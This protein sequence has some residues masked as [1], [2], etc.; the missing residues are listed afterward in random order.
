MTKEKFFEGLE[1]ILDEWDPIGILHDFKPIRYINGVKGEYS[2]YV[3]PFWIY[4]WLINLCMIF[5]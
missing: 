3:E 2:K 5:Y 4:T 1:K